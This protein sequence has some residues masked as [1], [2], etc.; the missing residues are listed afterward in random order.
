LRVVLDTNAVLELLHFS[1]TRAGR[2]RAAIESGRVLCLA[3]AAGIAEIERVAAYPEFRLDAPARR[4][5]LAAY[6]AFA[7][8]G[9]ADAS[10][11]GD[12]LPRCRDADDQKFLDLAAR[13]RA[14]ALITRDAQ[15]LRLA[16]RRPRP[17]F[18]ILTPGDAADAFGL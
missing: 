7:D 5:L 3:D 16:R 12:A 17:P 9:E 11:P 2:L 14:D 6:L 8:T 4:R 15:L 13:R 1:D 10:P 18:A